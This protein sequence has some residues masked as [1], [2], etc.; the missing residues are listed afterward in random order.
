M[1]RTMAIAIASLFILPIILFAAGV[2][3]VKKTETRDQ[4]RVVFDHKIH[5]NNGVSQC[6]ACHHKGR[7]GQACADSGCHV[8][9]AGTKAMHDRCKGCHMTK[10]GKAPVQCDQCHKK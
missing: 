1:K 6:K 9:P 2:V 8:G 5:Q 3:T 7:I 10:G 4:K